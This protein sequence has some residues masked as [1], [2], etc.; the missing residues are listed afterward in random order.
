VK[1]HRYAVTV[2]WTGN[3]GRGTADYRAYDRAHEIAGSADGK[4]PIPGSSD[5][6]FRG[7]RARWNPEELLVAALSACHELSYLHLCADAGVVVTSYTD[8]AEGVMVQEAD[9]GGQFREVVLRPVVT[10]AAG[11]DVE[12]A[13]V[14]HDRAHALCF[15]ARSVSFPVRHEPEVRVAQ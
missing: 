6:A 12:H 5:P 14:L 2:T 1:D 10:I 13:R 15:I 7:D 8:V 4:P 3:S 9:G 11:S